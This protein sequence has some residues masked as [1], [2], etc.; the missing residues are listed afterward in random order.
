MSTLLATV[1]AWLAL[2]V[3]ALHV[4]RPV[5]RMEGPVRSLA[6]RLLVA[7]ERLADPNFARTVVLLV[8]HDRRGALGLVVNRRLGRVPAARV[9][10]RLGLPD[11]GASGELEL[12]LGGPVEPGSLFVLH[13]DDR[14]SRDSREVA[15]GLLLTRDPNILADITRGRGPARHLIALGYAG[16]APGQLEAEI[17][18]GDWEVAELRPGFLFATEPEEM[19]ERARAQ[20]GVEL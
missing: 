8:R 5:E 9:L 13:S 18:R 10:A 17:A 14:R 2:L 19:W 3:P 6:G 1:F 4:D 12:A 11:E 20:A 16:W 7:D 15:P